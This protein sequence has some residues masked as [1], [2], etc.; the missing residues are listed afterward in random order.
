MT[1]LL[2]TATIFFNLGFL[3]HAMLAAGKGADNHPDA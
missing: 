1:A 2:I 3:F